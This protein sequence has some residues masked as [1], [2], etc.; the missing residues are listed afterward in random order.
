MAVSKPITETAMTA[1]V[2]GRFPDRAT[3]VAAAADL[4]GA[5]F[6]V[7]DVR[8]LTA[9]DPNRLRALGLADSQAR[10]FAIRPRDGGALLIVAAGDRAG[11][12]DAVL[13]RH[14]A[15]TVKAVQAVPSGEASPATGALAGA[16]AGAVAGGTAGAV[17]GGPVG[18]VI[19]GVVG[20]AAGA[21]AGEAIQRDVEATAATEDG[22][23]PGASGDAT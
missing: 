4:Y 8:V 14:G 23:P 22:R 1:V 12:A 21:T 16:A 18:A 13:A 11:E 20:A 15:V 9:A 17:A 2:L 5:G 10:R 3:A 7:P 19:G 6:F